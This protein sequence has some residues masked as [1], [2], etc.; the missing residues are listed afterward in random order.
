MP[1][2]ALWVVQLMLNWIKTRLLGRFNAARGFVG[3]AANCA[4]KSNAKVRVS[5]PHA[6]L[7]VVQPRR[8]Q[9]VC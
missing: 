1:H 5:M 3:G 6:A 4:R 8:D 9:K 2:A 7:L